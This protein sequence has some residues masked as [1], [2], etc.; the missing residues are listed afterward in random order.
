MSL[1][2]WGAVAAWLA[3]ACYF[4]WEWLGLSWTFTWKKEPLSASESEIVRRAAEGDARAL[5]FLGERLWRDGRKKRA[6]QC[7]RQSAE[8]G[9]VEAASTLGLLRGVGDELEREVWLRR[10]AQMAVEQG[11]PAMEVA[12]HLR[13]SKQFDQARSVLR[14]AAE[15]GDVEA[16]FSLGRELAG[17]VSNA[18]EAERYLCLAVDS[19]RCDAQIVLGKLLMDSGRREEGGHYL[20]LAVEQEVYASRDAALELG[21]YEWKFGHFEQADRYL[22]QAAALDESRSNTGVYAEFLCERGR[23]AELVELLRAKYGP[24]TGTAWLREAAD[25]L[26]RAGRPDEAA[27]YD[28]RADYAEH[29]DAISHIDPL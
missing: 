12:R 23:V 3:F 29:M 16:A 1:S 14:Q 20:R 28:A 4:G 11:L 17:T 8:A 13:N 10:A 19:G 25:L 15:S 18:A 7:Y 26:R 27:Q 9:F 5:Y 21:R 6:I 22:S 2:D 24:G